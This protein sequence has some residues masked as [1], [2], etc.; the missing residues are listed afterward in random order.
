M[1]KGFPGERIFACGL[2]GIENQTIT[3]DG[4]FEDLDFFVVNFGPGTWLG[5]EG[6]DE[7]VDLERIN[8]IESMLK[9]I[10]VNEGIG[11]G[12]CFVTGCKSC[13]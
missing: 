7:V 3:H 5:I 11:S 9:L 2:D 6:A 4:G 13:L 8:T 12:S 10:P 1:G